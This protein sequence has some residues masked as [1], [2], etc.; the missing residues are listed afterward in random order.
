MTKQHTYIQLK[1]YAQRSTERVCCYSHG[2]SKFLNKHVY[3]LLHFL[4][5]FQFLFYDRRVNNSQRLKTR[6]ANHQTFAGKWALARSRIKKHELCCCVVVTHTQSV[7]IVGVE[8]SF[9]WLS[10][11]KISNII[12]WKIPMHGYCF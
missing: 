6:A 5:H 1:S 9:S 11:H 10:S 7:F 12:E 4:L 8:K 3:I 2:F